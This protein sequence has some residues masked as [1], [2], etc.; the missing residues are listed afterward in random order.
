[1]D[2]AGSPFFENAAVVVGDLPEHGGAFQVRCDGIA[3]ARATPMTM[4][5][6]SLVFGEV[7]L[8]VGLTAVELRTREGSKARCEKYESSYFSVFKESFQ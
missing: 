3:C 8:R 5:S 2:P 7:S 6:A 1:L 4:D